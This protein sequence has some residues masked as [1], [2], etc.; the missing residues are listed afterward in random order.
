MVV[1]R[2][3]NNHY[4]VLITLTFSTKS[5]L[6][7]NLNLRRVIYRLDHMFC[8]DISHKEKF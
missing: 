1:N 3:I 7:M 2:I 5:K 8:K 4:Q 6:N